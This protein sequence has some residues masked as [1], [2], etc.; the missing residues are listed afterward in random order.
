MALYKANRSENSQE[1]APPSAEPTARKGVIFRSRTDHQAGPPAPPEEPSTVHSTDEGFE[2]GLSATKPTHSTRVLNHRTTMSTSTLPPIPT[3][4]RVPTGVHDVAAAASPAVQEVPVAAAPVVMQPAIP[5]DQAIIEEAQ[6]R[7]QQMLMEA[8]AAANQMLTEYQ[9]QAQAMM[10]QANQQIQAAAEQVQRQ[11]QEIGYQ[12]GFEQGLQQGGQQAQQQVYQFLMESR[13]IFVDAVRQR[14]LMLT[15]A[16]PELARL[17]VKLA[18]KLVG[19][20][21]Q[22][23]P[24]VILGVVRVALSGIGDREHVTVR[25]NP[26]DYDQVVAHRASFEKMIEGLK[27]FEVVADAAIDPGGCAIET[28]LGNIDARLNTRVAALMAGIEEQAQLH[29]KEIQESHAA[30]EPEAPELPPPPDGF[31]YAPQ[32][33]GDDSH[34]QAQE[35]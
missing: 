33:G 26:A 1:A 12:Q 24:E 6:Q 13:N 5:V 30:F 32:E 34:M 4:I 28:N 16:E 18:E 11:A 2:Q 22:L 31:G 29:E 3:A 7:A 19:Q 25:V 20:E 14:H 27:R 17:A 8:Q 9:H 23:N 35:E 15:N 10:E 21:L